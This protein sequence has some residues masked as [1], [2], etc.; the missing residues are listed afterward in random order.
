MPGSVVSAG[1]ATAILPL[2]EISTY[3]L[4]R[5]NGGRPARS[6]EVSR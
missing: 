1:L 6:M 3:V 2:D 4:A 5:V